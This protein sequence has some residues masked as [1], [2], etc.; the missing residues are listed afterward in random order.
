MGRMF[1][2]PHPGETIRED[3]LPELGITVTEAAR[4]LGVSRVTLSR[5]INGQ[6]GISADMAR[7][8]EAWL[9]G[10][11]R[12]PSAESWLRK[13]SDYDLWE[14]MQRPAPKVLRAQPATS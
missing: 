1:D 3:I 9:G 6:A 13:Q 10:P 14:A 12:G 8:L 7:R 4:Q 5:L 2:P 11:K